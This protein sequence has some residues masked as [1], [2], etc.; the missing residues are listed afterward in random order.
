MVF[1]LLGER[2]MQRDSRHYIKLLHDI[3]Q[4]AEVFAGFYYN[5]L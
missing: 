5:I 3:A 2:K 4:Y 1:V